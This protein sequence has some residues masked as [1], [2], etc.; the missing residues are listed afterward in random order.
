MFNDYYLK[1][2]LD[3]NLLRLASTR[4]Q[5]IDN[6]SKGAAEL[7]NYAENALKEIERAVEQIRNKAERS[8]DHE[9]EYKAQQALRL[10]NMATRR[11]AHILTVIGKNL[12][13]IKEQMEIIDKVNVFG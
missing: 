5:G 9:V 4:I 1:L 12:K 13:I 8:K 2:S 7:F 10:T 6:V 3:A 11:I